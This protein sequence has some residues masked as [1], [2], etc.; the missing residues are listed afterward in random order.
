MR[1][2]SEN[3]R[4]PY[5]VS[6]IISKANSTLYSQL[7]VRLLFLPMLCEP[8]LSGSCR[9]FPAELLAG[10]GMLTSVASVRFVAMGVADSKSSSSISMTLLAVGRIFCTVDLFDVDLAGCFGGFTA[11]FLVLDAFFLGFSTSEELPSLC[12]TLLSSSE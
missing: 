10:S 5:I 3:I 9:L 12:S 4:G 11:G 8:K 2:N 6:A 7:L 1:S